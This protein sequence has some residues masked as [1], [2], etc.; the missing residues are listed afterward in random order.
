[1]CMGASGI[2]GA[3]NTELYVEDLLRPGTT[4]MGEGE[5]PFFQAPDD[6]RACGT[7]GVITHSVLEKVEFSHATPAAISVTASL[8]KGPAA[9]CV[10]PPVKRF[11]FEFT[12][13]RGDYQLVSTRSVQ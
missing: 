6:V 1:V 11:R 3:S 5:A 9:G 13:D 8:G 10:A 2:M 12:F 7:D 4:L